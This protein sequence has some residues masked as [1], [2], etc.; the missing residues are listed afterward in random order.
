MPIVPGNWAGQRLEPFREQSP[1]PGDPPVVVGQVAVS[2]EAGSDSLPSVVSLPMSDA[3]DNGM[4]SEHEAD[5]DTS[6]DSIRLVLQDDLVHDE[7]ET[8]PFGDTAQPPMASP[9]AQGAHV[10]THLRE[11]SQAPPPDG[12]DAE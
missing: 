2:A 8:D 12:G 11:V 9:S 3:T 7:F 10:L 6:Q 5:G 4:H 1:P